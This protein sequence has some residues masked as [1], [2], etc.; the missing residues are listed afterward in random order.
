MNIKG[1]IVKKILNLLQLLVDKTYEK[2]GLSDDVLEL[3]VRINS[4]RREFDIVD[5]T[6]LID[7]TDFVQ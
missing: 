2:E 5:E 1:K 7:D 3:Q 4:L 6:H